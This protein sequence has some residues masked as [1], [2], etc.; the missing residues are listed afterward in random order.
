LELSV[1]KEFYTNADARQYI[2]NLNDGIKLAFFLYIPCNL[3]IIIMTGIYLRPLIVCLGTVFFMSLIALIGYYGFIVTRGRFVTHCVNQI[4][5]G[6]SVF[7]LN[8]FDSILFKEQHVKVVASEVGSE[9]NNYLVPTLGEIF[10]ITI[11][12]KKYYLVKKFLKDYDYIVQ[13]VSEMA[14]ESKSK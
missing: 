10:I 2:E 13:F 4:T 6:K 3:F 7:Q 1:S 8:T 9:I 5:F 14:I 12:G 11:S